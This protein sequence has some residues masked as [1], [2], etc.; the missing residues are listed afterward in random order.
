MKSNI[1]TLFFLLLFSFAILAQ[2]NDK[3][4]KEDKNPFKSETFDGLKFRCVG[5][6]ATSGRVV[7]FAVNPNDITE[8]YVAVACGNV[9]KTTNSG[10][11]WDPIFDKYGSHSIG[12]VSLDPNNSNVV[13]VGTGENNS[14]RS[15]SWGDGLYRSEDGGKS[16]KNIGLKKSEHIAKVL[17]D[18]RDSKVIY[19]A[20]QGPLWG[21]G[22]DRGLYKSTDYGTSWDSVLYISPNTGVTDVVMDPR[23]PDVLYAASYQRRRHVW[24]LINGGPEGAV[25]KS[26]DAGKTWNKLTS[27]LPSGDVGRIGLAISP[28]NPDYVYAIVEAANDG[29]GFYRSINRGASWEKM[30]DYKNVSAQYYS[31][32]FCDPVDVNKVYALDTYSSITTDGGKTFERISTK[33]RHVDDHAFWINPNNTNHFMI[34]G[35]GGIYETFDAAKTFRFKENLPTLQFYRVSVDNFEPFYRVMGGTQDNNSMIGPSQTINE[36]GIVNADWIPLV[37]GDG[38]EA[39]TDPSNPNIIYCEWQYGGLTRYDMQSGEQISIKPQERKDEAPYRWNWDTPLITSPHSNTRI[40]I[41][42]NKLFRSDDRGDSWQVISE[43]LT[44]QV[45]RNKLKIMDKVWSVDAV[46]KNA[47]T[48]F[49]GNIVSLTESPLVEGLLYVGTDDGLVQVTEDG[50][51]NWRKIEAFPGIPDMTYVSCLYASQHDANTVYATFDNHKRADFKPYI[52]VSNDRGKSWKSIAG[53]LKEP[54]VIYTFVQDHIKKDLYFVGTEYGVFFTNN[55][56]EK[57]IQ[58]KGNLPTQA[59]RD[60]D[61]QKREND[62][63]LATFGR[64]FYILDNYSA[65]REVAEESLNKE[66]YKLYPVKDA[67]MFTKRSA[68]FSG[69]GSSYYKADNPPF[70]AAFTYYIKEVPKTLK[71]QRQEKEKELI[72]KNEP[73]PYPSFEDLRKEDDEQK[74]FL[75]FT[76]YDA[77]GNVVRKL[78][79][80]VAAGLNRFTWDLR[81]ASTNPIKKA[82]DENPSG[83]PVMPGK[84]K[85]T[86]SISSNGVLKEVAGPVVFEAKVLNNVTLPAGDRSELAAFQKKVGELNSAVNAAIQVSSNLKDKVGI[87]KT[88]LKQTDDAPQSL[89]DEANRIFDENL[90]LYRKLVDDEVISSRNEPVYPSISARVGEVVGGMWSTTS[91]PTESYKQNYQIASEEFKPILERLKR[92]VEVDLK[93]LE[94]EM[95]KL[96]SPWTPGRVPDWKD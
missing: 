94:N 27:G 15:V 91:A 87:I 50:G 75:L 12:C 11:T 41:A 43:D 18:P 25:Y 66:N 62:L 63:A 8:Y 89:T 76:I 58:L 60:L 39:I 84:Y 23:N 3:D 33:G 73:V 55:G 7:D 13:Y 64:G 1:L 85:V 9:W 38:Y 26:T 59:V 6:A 48:S 61:I 30:S 90:A 74:S 20:A 32:I 37:G 54:Q 45:D 21:P 14:Q 4:K 68:T 16:F 83:Y 49:Y 40:Y 10:T 69:V 86:M 52:L 29:D 67:L 88:A 35:D 47:S 19:V 51:K 17:I 42:A 79:T 56:G 57:W 36:E 77:A 71:Q 22:G 34:G 80:N 78:K 53:D 70:G 95:D 93:N 65:L 96:N 5:P 82:T 2:D 72:K 46:A 28:V 44:R 92:L 31:E 81:Y 24:T